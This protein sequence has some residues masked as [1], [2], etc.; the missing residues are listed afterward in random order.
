MFFEEHFRPNYRQNTTHGCMGLLP[1]DFWSW[2][3]GPSDS[4]HGRVVLYVAQN[5]SRDARKEG[6]RKNYLSTRAIHTRKIVQ[7]PHYRQRQM[8]FARGRVAKYLFVYHGDV[9]VAVSSDIP[10]RR[11][12]VCYVCVRPSSL[13]RLEPT[14]KRSVD[15]VTRVH[16]AASL[17]TLVQT[18]LLPGS[19]SSKI[20]ITP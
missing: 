10:L 14:R 17:Q 9:C 1:L 8:L 12:C 5:A 2:T 15:A 6:K 16:R 3:S 11:T 7:G 13:V 19:S 4:F 20:S 18:V